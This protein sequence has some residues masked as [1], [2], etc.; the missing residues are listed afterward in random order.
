MTRLYERTI[1]LIAIVDCSGSKR[2]GGDDCRPRLRRPCRQRV[3]FLDYLSCS[4]SGEDLDPRALAK[5]PRIDINLF[6]SPRYSERSFA[7]SDLPPRGW[8]DVETFA[9]S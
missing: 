1:C 8:T 7:V 2:R 4:L 5:Q 6:S 3:I 9:R